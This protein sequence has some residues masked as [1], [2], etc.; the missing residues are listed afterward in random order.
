MSALAPP[1]AGSGEP[2]SGAPA[3]GA[4]RRSDAVGHAGLVRAGLV[5]LAV[6]PAVIGVWALA[7]P[8][9]FYDAFPGT[10]T[11]WVSALGPYDEHLVRDVGA[12]NLAL[13][14]LLLI[15]A[16]RMTRSLVEAALVVA[17]V[18]ALPHAIF[19]LT[20]RG[21]LPLADAIV[22]DAGL[23]LV[24]VLPLALLWAVRRPGPP[25]DDGRSAL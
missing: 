5:A 2:G 13:A 4:R 11:G 12:L 15:A 23:V 24:V 16:A 7:A 9:G 3:D 22:S 8:R 17:A 21:R 20:E 19:H 25:P 18:A 6:V 10:N 1:S 14:L